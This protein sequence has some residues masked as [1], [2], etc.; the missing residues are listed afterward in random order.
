MPT[1][2][3]RPS[4]LPQRYHIPP[5]SPG[6]LTTFSAFKHRNYRLYFFGLLISVTGLWSQVVAQSW[7]VYELTDSA[8][9]IGQVNAVMALPVWL[10]GPWAGVLI[11]R[12]PRRMILL[13]TQIV[14]MLQAIT[15]AVLTF[16]G[17]IEV[18][19]IMV[20]S[21]VRGVANAFD[22]PTRQAFVVEM[23]GKEDLSNAIALNS[24]MFS[25]ART[26]GPS[27]GGLIIASLGTAWAFT[28]NALTFLAIIGALLLMRL[29]KPVLQPS[30]TSPLRDLIEGFR[31]IW[32][33][34][35]IIGLMAIAFSVA[36][37]GAN[38]QTLLPLVTDRVLGR[39]ET[40]FGLLNGANGLGTLIGTLLVA[41]LANQARRGRQLNLF[42]LLFPLA[43]LAFAAS[44]SYPLS[45]FFIA[46]VGINFIPQLSLANMLIQD[47]IEDRVRGRVMSVYTLLI[48]GTAPIGSY[49]AGA[50]GEWLGAPMAIVISAAA[51]IV[52]AVAVRVAVPGMT[53]LD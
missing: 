10:L 39:G 3:P 6:W 48:F 37:F 51:M 34:K 15:L 14:Q 33:R 4:P 7:L 38:F 20:L 40:A 53:K 30:E 8:L 36:L 49:I 29:P 1:P 46:L 11:D 25:L 16:T 50:L 52:V 5:D 26:I 43:L 32:Q 23:V 35:T 45:L 47:N 24:S 19:H 13:T 27:I 28:V 41:Y 9:A 22:A 31:Y 44:R 18:W 21:G 42:N 17:Q 12:V 2:P